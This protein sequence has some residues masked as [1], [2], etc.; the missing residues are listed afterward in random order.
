MIN[1]DDRLLK[2]IDSNEFWL[3]CHITKRLN[4]DR[5]CWPSNRMLCRETGWSM[6]K[7]QKYKKQLI[8]KDILSVIVRKHPEGGQ[9]SNAY[10][11]KCDMIGIFVP[12]SDIEPLQENTPPPENPRGTVKNG[13]PIPGNQ[14]TEVLNTE[15]LNISLLLK[16][17]NTDNPQKEVPLFSEDVKTPTEAKDEMQNTVPA[18][19]DVYATCV[20]FWLKEFHPG[21]TFGA[22]QGKAMKSIIKKIKAYCVHSGLK[23]TDGQSIASFKKMCQTLPDWF[24]DKDLQ[25]L[26]SKF[27]EIITQILQGNPKNNFNSLNSRDRVFGKYAK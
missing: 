19:I 17:S 4:K 9:G 11:I 12:L 7:L 20:N 21:F 22:I 15:V 1:I 25:V 2:K 3:L 5:I 13:K 8:D 26:D 14:V 10:K 23:G 27:N 24:K 6:D 16:K 18:P